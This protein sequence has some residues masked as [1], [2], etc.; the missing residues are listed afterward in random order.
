AEAGPR[1][2]AELADYRREWATMRAEACTATRVDHTQ[3]EALLDLRNLCLDDRLQALSAVV[4]TL[5]EPPVPDAARAHEMA[6][7]LP[8][9]ADCADTAWLLARVKPP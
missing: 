1:V 2:A 3:S 5:H 9:I 4:A 6:T 7:S 8:R